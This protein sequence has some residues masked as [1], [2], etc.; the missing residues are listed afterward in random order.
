MAWLVATF[1]ILSVI[2]FTT[3]FV[4]TVIQ[5]GSHANKKAPT[6]GKIF[7]KV[8]IYVII[9]PLFILF[10]PVAYWITNPDAKKEHHS[11]FHFYG[12]R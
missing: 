2:T 7:G 11:F 9:T 6:L 8:L 1:T 12:V 4:M 5:A 10:S 3:F